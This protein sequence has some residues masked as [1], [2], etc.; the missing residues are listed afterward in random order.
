MLT[1][2]F[3]DNY[4]TFE[5]FTW[6]PGQVA[7]VMGRNG[8]GKSSLFDLLYAVREFVC[9]DGTVVSCF[10]AD[11]RSRWSARAEQVFE[12]EV[13]IAAGRFI[14]RLEVEHRSGGEDSRVSRETLRTATETLFEFEKGTVRL[15]DDGGAK[16]VEF[17]APGKQSA[18]ASVVPD[19]SNVR[20]T[21]FRT[22]LSDLVV[23][24]PNPMAMDGRALAENRR[25]V[26]GLENFASW[27]RYAQLN[28][29]KD[30]AAVG[31]AFAEIVPQFRSMNMRV[32]EQ[33]VGWLR[34]NFDGPDGR[35]YSLRF[36]E[37]SDG[38]RVL[39]ALYTI[40]HTEGRGART[41]VLDEPDNF[42]ALAEIQPFIFELLDR[43]MAEA[44]SQLFVAS[45]HPEYLDQLAPAYGWVVDR[46]S[47]DASVIRRFK[48]DVALS[49][50]ALVAR[51]ELATEGEDEA[52][53]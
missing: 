22:W 15:Y 7:F 42:V 32:D 23:V 33:R 26:R 36:E 53:R 14:Y 41:V 10:P 12:L 4:R 47:G 6:A 39:F 28:Q 35:P 34:A 37:L 52:A 38:Q 27:Y 51:D 5:G 9:G 40:L 8:S 25:L 49:A 20:L 43:A 1:R 44:G 11:S 18:L 46:P 17:K 45:H 21:A 48:A 2:L 30:M 50:S 19:A 31:Q 13:E 16:Q 24:R 29:P 3:I